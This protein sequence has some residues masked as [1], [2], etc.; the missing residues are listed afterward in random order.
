MV[1]IG[2]SGVRIKLGG[3]RVPVES[4]AYTVWYVEMWEKQ[5]GELY[6][7]WWYM[8]ILGDNC[9]IGAILMNIGENDRG[10]CWRK[11]GCDEGTGGE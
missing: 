3:H 10:E 8:E 1:L 4:E 7:E 6:D 2:T 11:V 5:K 9:E